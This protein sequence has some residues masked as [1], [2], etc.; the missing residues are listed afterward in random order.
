MPQTN[1]PTDIARETFKTLVARRIA[2][3][4]EN[5][6]KIYHEIAGTKPASD[7]VLDTSLKQALI[8]IGQSSAQG[9][10]LSRQLETA[11]GQRDGALLEQ[12]L[13]PFVDPEAQGRP[14]WAP[15]IRDLLQQ[16]ETRHAGITTRRKR[17]GLDRVL[18]NFGKD[19]QQ[20][21]IRLQNLIQSWAES[22]VQGGIETPGEEIEVPDAGATENAVPTA[23]TTEPVL[24]LLAQTLE[25]G[26]AARLVRYPDLY[27]EAMLLCRQARGARDPIALQ[28]LGK[29]LKQF[30][31]KLELRN[32][33]DAQIF[34]GLQEL[35][36]LFVDNI[37]ELVSDDQWLQ[38]QIAIVS[39]II[40]QPLSRRTLVDAQ[41]SFKEV[42]YKQ[43]AL[44][45][46]LQDAK[47]TLKSMITTFVDRLGEISTHTG[48]YHD[49][50][51]NYTEQISHTEDIHQLNQ[52][53]DSLLSD[54]RGM[55]LDMLRSREE[56]DEARRRVETAEEKVRQLQAELEHVSEMVREDQLTGLLNRRGLEEELDREIARADRKNLPLSLSVLDVDNFKR[57][58][59]TY[60]HQAGDAA[61]T[62]LARVVKD[63]LRPTDVVAR[64]GG[65]EFII[66]LPDTEQEEAVK[67]MTRV[68]RE[69][70]KQ[71]FL[72][73]N[74]RM[75][76]TFSAGVAQRHV[77]EEI[78]SVIARA[79]EAVYRAK[80]AGRN[81][82]LPAFDSLD[83][84]SPSIS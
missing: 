75:L 43:G 25:F 18:Q 30:W 60:G 37:S 54:T 6:Q 72:H 58:N 31:M 29:N 84:P 16:I 66:V 63:A 82:V 2:P 23:R 56:I 15:L 53:L 42:I 38:G 22:P 3:T 10:Q 55:Q 77:E 51:K 44:K 14:G 13:K 65:E 81:R 83:A 48:Q 45:K 8:R 35:L 76:I 11:L 9:R 74:Q 68:Q 61:L 40:A 41:R 17:E 19:P 59:D 78:A 33:D 27:D 64:F 21:P 28:A 52:I 79:D 36:R 62:H 34:T 1:N 71:F 57:L 47:A 7:A 39:D 73:N 32:E 80:A 49:K 67:V 26:V 46:S 4:P 70:T 50:I 69:L 5:Y 20:L 24:D 12:A